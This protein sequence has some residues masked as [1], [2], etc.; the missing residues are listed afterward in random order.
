MKIK[1]KKLNAQRKY[2]GN[3]SFGYEPEKDACL[4]P[5]C[6]IKGTVRV[7]GDYEIYADD[8]VGVNFTVSYVLEGQCS[9]CLNAARKEIKKDF[10]VLFVREKDPDNYYYDG[11]TVNLK[12]AVDDAILFSQPDVILCR[13]DCTGIDVNQ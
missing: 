3:F 11:I 12:T 4:I 7:D 2:S 13:D 6:N 1:V 8:S 9:Y 5:L 10:E